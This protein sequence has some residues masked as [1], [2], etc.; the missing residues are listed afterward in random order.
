MPRIRVPGGYFSARVLPGVVLHLLEAERDAL[1]L[2]VELEHHDVDLVADLEHL[3]R[4]VDP[5]PG[6]VGDVQQAVDAAEV[7][8]GAV[9]GEVLDDALDDL[10]F[11]EL[12]ER[13]LLLLGALLLEHGLARQHDVAAPLV[14][15]DDLQAEL[16]ADAGFQ[17]AHGPDV[18]QRA[19]KEGA[20]GRCRP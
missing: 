15:L 16:L 4:V 9:L 6:H 5:A 12:V 14:D 7:D 10:A 19:G 8:E 11:L 13:L 1:A 2:G 20:A 3:G 17:V 18:D